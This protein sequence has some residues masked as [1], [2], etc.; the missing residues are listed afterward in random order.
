MREINKIVVHHSAVTQPDLNK[1]IESFNIT[2]RATFNR[3][4]WYEWSEWIQYHY[5]IWIDWEVR[6]IAPIKEVL[7][8]ASNFKIN[9]ESIGICLSGNFD[10]HYP[11]PKQYWALLKLIREHKLPVHYHN[12][13]ST[14]TCPWNNFDYKLIN[15]MQIN[16]KFVDTQVTRV[17]RQKIDKYFEKRQTKNDCTRY[18][19]MWNLADIIGRELTD[20]EVKSFMSFSE[21]FTDLNS[22]SNIVIQMM[23]ITQW[24]NLN[25]QEKI[26]WYLSKD[27]L[28]DRIMGKFMLR[29]YPIVFNRVA[30]LDFVRDRNADWIINWYNFEKKQRH[31]TRFKL[32]DRKIIEINNYAWEKNNKFE[33]EDFLKFIKSWNTRL[34]WFLYRKR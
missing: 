31:A 6:K 25:N 30:W 4:K 27:F 23:L 33:Y 24:W 1:A 29:W 21:M 5:V 13:Y 11:T 32:K 28:K 20:N 19:L 22:A 8:H 7:Y 18:A 34:F 2:H 14:K 12:E 16:P 15:F 10:V 9:Q 26:W 3:K 17:K